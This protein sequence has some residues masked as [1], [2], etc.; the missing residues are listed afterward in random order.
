LLAGYLR[1][2]E[3]PDVQRAPTAQN[4]QDFLEQSK[5]VGA[6][7]PFTATK[8]QGGMRDTSMRGGGT[9]GSRWRQTAAPKQNALNKTRTPS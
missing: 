4:P 8:S 1:C 2:V 3:I 5:F 9:P 6:R 7:N